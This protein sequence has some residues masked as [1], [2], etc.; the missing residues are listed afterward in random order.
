LAKG[1]EG[2]PSLSSPGAAAMVAVVA[3]GE[4]LTAILEQNQDRSEASKVTLVFRGQG[5]Y[6]R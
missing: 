2:F 4:E 6:S 3:G 1:F 5:L